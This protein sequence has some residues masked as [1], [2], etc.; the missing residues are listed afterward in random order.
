MKRKEIIMIGSIVGGLST[1]SFEEQKAQNQEKISKTL[2]EKISLEVGYSNLQQEKWI[3]TLRVS[4][5][6]LEGPPL[7]KQKDDSTKL[8]KLIRIFTSGEYYERI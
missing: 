1:C 3:P 5:S 2:S 6:D 8:L 4:I 7:V